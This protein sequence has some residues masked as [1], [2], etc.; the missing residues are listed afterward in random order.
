RAAEYRA[1]PFA[2]LALNITLLALWHPVDAGTLMIAIL[3]FAALYALGG[4][5]LQWK[6][7][8]PFYWAALSV[9]A[10]FTFFALG[11]AQL[12]DTYTLYHI[13][14]LLALSLACVATHMVMRVYEGFSAEHKDRNAMLALYAGAAAGFISI[15]LLIEVPYEFLSVAF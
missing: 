6:A 4:H 11:Y 10:A 2:T 5:L 3:C 14:T 8:R 1:I 12:H 13:W 15:G 7:P 9:T